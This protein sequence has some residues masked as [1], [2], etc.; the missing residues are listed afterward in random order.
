MHPLQIIEIGGGTGTLAADIMASPIGDLVFSRCWE[1]VGI[2]HEM[3]A[4]V[5]S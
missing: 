1:H 2:A 3:S 5:I 4:Y